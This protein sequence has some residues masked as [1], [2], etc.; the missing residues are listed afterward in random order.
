ML[1]HVNLH[2]H[3]INLKT[4]KR[5]LGLALRHFIYKLRTIIT[6]IYLLYRATTALQSNA[7]VVYIIRIIYNII[8]KPY[9]N[10]V[11]TALPNPQHMS[12]T[13]SYL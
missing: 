13:S 7:V 1:L 4:F 8:N 10:L 3:Y 2:K 6:T 5:S 11:D 12:A 9:L